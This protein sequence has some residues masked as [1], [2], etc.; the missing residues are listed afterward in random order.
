MKIFKICFLA[1]F[2]IMLLSFATETAYSSQL[3]ECLQILPDLCSHCYDWADQQDSCAAL[4][5]WSMTGFRQGG[6]NKAQ[7]AVF[8][9]LCGKVCEA[10]RQGMK[11][12]EVVDRMEQWCRQTVAGN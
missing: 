11:K 4:E 5:E 8:A 7:A 6:L 3:D 10:K 9:K 2:C 12:W 1:L